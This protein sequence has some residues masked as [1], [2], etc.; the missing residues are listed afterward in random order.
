MLQYVTPETLL[1][2]V[3]DIENF[4]IAGR[5]LGKT[6]R[7]DSQAPCMQSHTGN[8]HVRFLIPELLS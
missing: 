1:I 6:G 2:S 5:L 7:T 3:A 4:V 8:C